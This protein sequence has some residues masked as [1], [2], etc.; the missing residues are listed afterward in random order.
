M[1]PREDGKEESASPTLSANGKDIAVVLIGNGKS[2]DQP[3]NA[4]LGFWLPPDSPYG[5]FQLKLRKLCDRLDEANRRLIDT[6]D[7]WNKAME[8]KISANSFQRHEYAIE[9]AVYLMRRVADELI[10]MIWCLDEWDKTGNYPHQIRID[11]IGAALETTQ[12][13]LSKDLKLLF[14]PHNPVMKA[15][16]E[17]SNAF[18]HS[19]VHSDLTL[20]GR[21]EPCVYALGLAHNK[22]SSEMKFHNFSVSWLVNEFSAFYKSGIQW[23]ASFSERHRK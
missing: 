16:N 2:P 21:D 3:Y 4:R 11:C 8:G 19:F 13:N 22:L 12:Q 17:I 20:T 5:N 18:K 7:Y 23:L 6:F 14:A 9:Q 10:A 1:P 15:L